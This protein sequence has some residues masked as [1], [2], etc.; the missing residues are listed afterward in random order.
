MLARKRNEKCYYLIYEAPV[1]GIWTHN[2]RLTV[3]SFVGLQRQSANRHSLVTIQRHTDLAFL[4]FQVQVEC[5]VMSGLCKGV[6]VCQKLWHPSACLPVD[7][8]RC[9]TH[10]RAWQG[11][12]LVSSWNS[13]VCHN[14][15][16]FNSHSDTVFSCTFSKLSDL[17]IISHFWMLRFLFDLWV[18]RTVE[19]LQWVGALSCSGTLQQYCFRLT[20]HS[21]FLKQ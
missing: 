13:W 2:G 17:C 21:D 6:Y 3:R 4:L 20:H 15:L 14:L 1:P 11:T 18:T 9:S 8:A 10:H 19:K 7:S 12:C 16:H 5:N